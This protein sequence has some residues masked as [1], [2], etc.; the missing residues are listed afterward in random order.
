MYVFRVMP[1]ALR[2]GYLRVFTLRVLAA[3]YRVPWGE[4]AITEFV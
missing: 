1:I 2:S 3:A 4:F